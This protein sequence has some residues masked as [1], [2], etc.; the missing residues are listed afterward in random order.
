MHR[1]TTISCF[2]NIFSWSNV[3]SAFCI[4]LAVTMLT[5]TLGHGRQGAEIS[6]PKSP[7]SPIPISAICDDILATAESRKRRMARLRESK[8]VPLGTTRSISPEID[9]ACTGKTIFGPG[10]A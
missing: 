5:T 1:S 7:G 9:A 3:E 2:S 8:R 6:H 10:L 4:F